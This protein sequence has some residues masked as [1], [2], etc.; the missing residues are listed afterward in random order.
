MTP[1]EARPKPLGLGPEELC[2]GP[3]V[4]KGRVQTVTL[5]R[6]SM[7]ARTGGSEGATEGCG[8]L[9]PWHWPC[10]LVVEQLTAALG[11]SLCLDL[12]ERCQQEQQLGSEPRPNRPNGL[13]VLECGRAEN[14][15][16]SWSTCNSSMPLCD[17]GHA[18]F[19][20]FVPDESHLMIF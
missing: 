10:A 1:N 13:M 14:A 9:L 4:R 7:L 20:S 3:I 15:P 18:F 8:S 17:L 16:I 19:A 2:R 12:T 6:Q 5:M 11:G